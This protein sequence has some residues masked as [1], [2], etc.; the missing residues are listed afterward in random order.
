MS[1]AD[2]SADGD[3]DDG[4][5]ALRRLADAYDGKDDAFAE[6]C[7]RLAHSMEEINS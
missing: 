7:A 3:A 5:E 4:A 6:L 1:R 2:Q